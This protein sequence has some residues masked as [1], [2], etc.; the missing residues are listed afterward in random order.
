MTSI[1]ITQTLQNDFVKPLKPGEPLPNPLHVGREEAKRLIGQSIEQGPV[2]RFMAWAE[3]QLP[4][5]LNIIHIRDWHNA[6]APEQVSHLQQFGLHCIEGTEG[7]EFIFPFDE[8]TSKQNVS[9]INSTTLNDFEGTRLSE[10]L[11][12]ICQNNSEKKCRIGIIGVWTEAKVLFLAYELATRFPHTEIAVCSALTASA[13]RSQHFLALQQLERIVGVGVIHS[14]GEFASFLSQAN[15]NTFATS[16]LQ[17]SFNK[18]LIIESID[19]FS[20][21]EETERLIRYLYRDCQKIRMRILD[22]GFSGNLVAGVISTDMFGH[23]Q[24]PHVIK[25]GPRDLMARERTAFEQIENV[26]GNNAP[27]IADYID[28]QTKGALKYRYATMIGGKGTSGVRSLQ[29]HFE[30]CFKTGV[31]QE[32]LLDILEVVFDEQLGRLYRAA[33]SDKRNLLQYY[34]FDSGWAN[35]VRK[36]IIDLIGECPEQG[37]LILPGDRKAPNLYQFYNEELHNLP[38]TEGDYPF[39]FVHGDLNGANVMIDGQDNVWLIDFF[40]THRGHV[41]KDFA[42]LE[43]DLLFI[44]TPVNSDQDLQLAF[45]FS[46]FLSNFDS[47]F[48]NLPPLPERFAETQ[49]EVTYRF[50]QKIRELAFKQLPTD[51]EG[52]KLQ[53]LV[54]QLRYSVH[55]IGFDEPNRWQR[56]LAL[57]SSCILSRQMVEISL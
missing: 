50:I 42:K 43:N 2:G 16:P 18:S 39:S 44:Y 36:K 55:T 38:Q 37:G 34:C 46:D 14:V 12:S 47:P 28:G 30:D 40:H 19:D 53:W 17:K 56:I 54:A 25:I 4:S 5:Q 31:G 48:E 7:A 20:Q 22:G 29:S 6:T 13:S 1:L 10:T 26:L 24:T 51:V 32:K 23:E 21:D 33:V 49:F 9:L 3:S 11:K 15:T 8:N 52:M 35:S 27:A 41:L 45:A 57:Y